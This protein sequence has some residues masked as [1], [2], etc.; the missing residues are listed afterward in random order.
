MEAFKCPAKSIFC[1]LLFLFLLFSSP[2]CKKDDPTLREILVG[3]WESNNWE[4]NGNPVTQLP[5]QLEL[6][7]DGDF[8]ITIISSSGSI[9]YA[10][11]WDVNET[12]QEL[13]LDYDAVNGYY[14]LTGLLI[15]QIIPREEFDVEFK[16]GELFLEGVNASVK[17]EMKLESQ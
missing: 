12:K 10:G 9:I 2:G 6:D 3:E 7:A 14:G 4:I 11:D 8:T 17:I 13:E 5:L 15:E 1:S 16:E